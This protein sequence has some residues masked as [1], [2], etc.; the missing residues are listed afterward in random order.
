MNVPDSSFQAMTSSTTIHHDDDINV[1][2]EV[3]SRIKNSS[4]DF[5]FDDQFFIRTNYLS[6]MLSK[7]CF[8]HH[9]DMTT[10][11]STWKMNRH[12]RQLFLIVDF[13]FDQLLILC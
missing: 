2:D 4:F 9:D 8:D 7:S 12:A 1:E 11:S 13:R 6:N 3:P 10:T 5:N